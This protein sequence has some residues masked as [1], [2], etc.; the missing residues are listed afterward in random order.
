MGIAN[1]R[2][3]GVAALI[4]LAAGLAGCGQGEGSRAGQS[5]DEF[6]WQPAR[7]EAAT[8]VFTDGS[9]RGM[10]V[11]ADFV[12]VGRFTGACPDRTMGNGPLGDSV[13]Y[14]CLTFE[15]SE[16][17]V[18]QGPQRVAVE[19]LAEFPEGAHPRN[20][21]VVFLVDKGG[22][23][24]GRYRAVNS[25]GIFT[26]TSEAPVDQPLRVED[27]DLDTLALDGLS[28]TSWGEFV[29]TLRAGLG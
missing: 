2:S 4:P 21:A 17:L 13:T 5:E 6:S 26:E 15:S 10:A 12:A 9:V 22:A 23:E 19:F 20:E 25:S 28:L 7:L 3:V 18:G 16:F 11:E 14:S 1:W 29:T 27:A 8:E 24:A